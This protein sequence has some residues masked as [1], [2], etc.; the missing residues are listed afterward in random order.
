MLAHEEGSVRGEYPGDDER[1]EAVCP[2]DEHHQ[3]IE[4]AAMFGGLGVAGKLARWPGAAVAGGTAAGLTAAEGGT[5]V[6]IAT[7]GL[8][9]GALRAVGTAKPYGLDARLDKL[10]YPKAYRNKMSMQ[11]ARDAV[12]YGKKFVAPDPTAAASPTEPTQPAG[13]PGQMNLPLQGREAVSPEGGAP[14]QPGLPLFSRKNI[15]PGQGT[16]DVNDIVLSGRGFGDAEIAAMHPALKMAIVNSNHT[17][18]TNGTITIDPKTGVIKSI[19]EATPSK[20]ETISGF[21]MK[22]ED[23]AADQAKGNAL[24][25][26]TKAAL[27]KIKKE[28]EPTLTT[29]KPA[30]QSPIGKEL[31]DSP[32]IAAEEAV[33][34]TAEKY[35]GKASDFVPTK[36]WQEVSTKMKLPPGLETYTNKA[37]GTRLV[38]LKPEAETPAAKA[39]KTAKAEKP[40]VDPLI[41]TMLRT[42][43]GVGDNEATS[44]AKWL[45]SNG[46]KTV[47]EV[48]EYLKTLPEYQKPTTAAISAAKVKGNILPKKT[49]LQHILESDKAAKE[50]AE[51]EGATPALPDFN[52]KEA[53]ARLTEARD[54]LKKGQDYVDAF[55][56]SYGQDPEEAITVLE[57][58]IPKSDVEK[59]AAVKSEIAK[60]EEAPKPKP[61]LKRKGTVVEPAPFV[62]PEPG[63]KGA[64]ILS[65]TDI[66]TVKKVKE[67]VSK[68]A[69]DVAELK[70][71][72]K[73]MGLS[74]DLIQGLSDADKA[75]L[76]KSWQLQRDQRAPEILK[77][78]KAAEKK[79]VA[80]AKTF[81]KVVTQDPRTDPILRNLFAKMDALEKNIAEMKDQ[82]R[83]GSES[84]GREQLRRMG[85]EKKELLQYIEKRRHAIQQEAKTAATSKSGEEKIITLAKNDFGGFIVKTKVSDKI[86]KF[87]FITTQEGKVPKPEDTGFKIAG[88]VDV[89]RSSGQPIK[90]RA[91]DKLDIGEADY[92]TKGMDDAIK[93]HYNQ[94]GDRLLEPGEKGIKL[95]TGVDPDVL[96]KAGQKV[97][98]QVK[99]FY[100]WWYER[101]G[102]RRLTK[103]EQYKAWHDIEDV[104]RSQWDEDTISAVR[105]G[106]LEEFKKEGETVD[107]VPRD[108]TQSTMMSPA[109]VIFFTGPGEPTQ[110]ET[111]ML[112]KTADVIRRDWAAQNEQLMWAD[113]VITSLRQKAET[114]G[115]IDAPDTVQR[116]LGGKLKS[117]NPIL[118][119]VAEQMRKIYDS[120]ADSPAYKDDL[121]D[122][123]IDKYA[124]ALISMDKTYDVA[125]GIFGRAKNIEDLPDYFQATMDTDRFNAS[126]SIFKDYHSWKDIPE[127]KRNILRENVFRFSGGI[128]T[129]GAL[130]LRTQDA[131]RNK[132]TWNKHL[133]SREGHFWEE[134][135]DAF[136]VMTD[137]LHTMIRKEYQRSLKRDIVGDMN[138]WPDP[139]RPYSVRW[140][141]EKMLSQALHDRT[142]GDYAI[143]NMA[144]SVN[145]IVGKN[146]IDSVSA[147][148]KITNV[149][150]RQ[151]AA[152]VLGYPT[153]IKKIMAGALNLWADKGAGAFGHAIKDF[154]DGKRMPPELIQMLELI[155]G[156]EGVEKGK[157]LGA[158]LGS[159]ESKLGK[160]Y[161]FYKWIQDRGLAPINWAQEFKINLTFLADMF[162]QGQKGATKE[163]A[164]RHGLAKVSTLIPD[165]KISE[166]IWQ[167][168]QAA[169]R[170]QFGFKGAY[171]TP[172]SRGPLARMGTLFWSFP[173]KEFQFLYRGLVDSAIG[174]DGMRFTRFAL[175]TGG[176]LWAISAIINL[177]GAEAP[178]IYKFGFMPVKPFAMTWDLIGN[179][180]EAAFGKRADDRLKGSEAMWNSVAAYGIPQ[181]GPGKAVY[182]S[183]KALDKG[184]RT[185]GAK[186]MPISDTSWFSEMLNVMGFHPRGPH[187]A[188][189]L[190]REMDDVRKEHQWKKEKMLLK[191]SKAM[192]KGDMKTVQ[193]VFKDAQEQNVALSFG[194][195]Q[196]YHRDRQTQTYLEQRL[197]SVPRHL[198]GPIQKKIDELQSKIGPARNEEEREE[199]SMW[200]APKQMR[201]EGEE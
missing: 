145:N 130:P 59:L 60:T 148:S 119:E 134:K 100:R 56:A 200:S 124:P 7:S 150:T 87:Q 83:A 4:H 111:P 97:G 77:T 142:I 43:F 24:A 21:K 70:E 18:G 181:Y 79:E 159:A 135:H 189:D 139:K 38:R 58:M 33:K 133:Q 161:E 75:S 61:I 136:D 185:G 17:G 178:S 89:D 29:Y 175:L 197:K 165:T 66:D 144:N 137:Y 45:W 192:E 47:T 78:E 147:G 31:T 173:V 166:S 63:E 149:M 27:G 99:R 12:K 162:E 40:V 9:M 19:K 51:V 86:D 186:E 15:L 125:R 16:L 71:A 53:Q 13:P 8:T 26:K 44:V 105:Y 48:R 54:A 193:D 114:A 91:L 41:K 88:E 140:G 46:Q 104:A 80:V 183:I 151:A 62:S 85:Q 123:R 177:M 170:D 49:L 96:A 98:D 109:D 14:G 116:M 153:A 171:R 81:N 106:E 93:N 199:K 11:E 110:L 182:Q 120:V 158:R 113:K 127:V 28:K 64:A 6:D 57:S 67:T 180:Y 92:L 5:P 10:G 157:G 187:M 72:T 154:V 1:G 184:Y 52:V 152:G 50:G 30:F 118:L 2:A 126:M 160:G 37:K 188:Y 22:V 195:L 129:F 95:Y 168:S 198:R 117:N 167:A 42:R 190:T 174:G 23:I 121:K 65:E 39:A 82:Y 76:I 68:E 132:N 74:P 163:T 32:E 25:E 169:I 73:G 84:V 112:K 141:V 94:K 179:A 196:R 115:I 176:Q 156:Y 3:L 102:K 164:F 101:Q 143:Q 146:I 103:E 122:I 55:K 108:P 36:E 90:V 35:T 194:S 131:I 34:A 138:A 172:L 191:A 201:E 128:D 107:L 155:H 20:G 69:I